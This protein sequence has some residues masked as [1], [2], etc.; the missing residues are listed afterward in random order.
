MFKNM[1]IHSLG[2]DVQLATFATI[3]ATIIGAVLFLLSNNSGVLWIIS[4]FIIASVS[5]FLLPELLTKPSSI[6]MDMETISIRTRFGRTLIYPYE[7]ISYIKLGGG[8]SYGKRYGVFQTIF[9]TY[10]SFY[11]K[12]E[13]T[14]ALLQRCQEKAKNMHR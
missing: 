7:D 3:S 5:G 12:Y 14:E 13:I 6:K 4:I 2:K 11:V 9:Q 10:G 1:R 8:R